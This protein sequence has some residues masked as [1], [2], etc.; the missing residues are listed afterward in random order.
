MEH[1]HDDSSRDKAPDAPLGETAPVAIGQGGG[2][3]VRHEDP[4]PASGLDRGQGPGRE[5]LEDDE[6]IE[7][8]QPFGELRPR[9]CPG[10]T[11]WQ[12]R[13][14]GRIEIRFRCRKAP[15][16]E[17]RDPRGPWRRRSQGTLAQ[18]PDH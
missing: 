10:Q 18:S 13:S 16:P 7:I 17:D 15:E 1:K 5:E 2:V 3:E 9:R 11:G 6:E 14:G 12:L 8:R 4:A